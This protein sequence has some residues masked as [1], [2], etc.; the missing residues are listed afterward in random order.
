LCSLRENGY[1]PQ[2]VIREMIVFFKVFPQEHGVFPKEM[3]GE[4]LC[5]PREDHSLSFSERWRIFKGK[6]K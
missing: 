5:C 3:I 6:I 1:V 2:G 4:W